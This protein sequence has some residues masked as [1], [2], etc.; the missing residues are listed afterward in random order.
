[1]SAQDEET[2]TTLIKCP[3]VFLPKQQAV[4]D[5][6]EKY[7]YVL[8]S[9][10]FGAGK[11]FLMSHVIIRN[12]IKY[13]KSLAF[14]GSQTVPLL[15]DTVVRTFLEEIDVYQ[16][17]IT[18]AG[19]ELQLCK[20][21]SPSIMKFTFFNGAEVLFRSC[22]EPS[23]F[24]SLNLDCMAIDEP[25]DIDEEVFLMLQGRLRSNKTPHRFAIMAGNP[26]GKT[27][28]VY[29]RFYEK[30]HK[31]Y[32]YVHTTTF[33]NTYLPKDYI[34]SVK[35]SYDEDYA[36]RYLYGEW[37][38]FEG[39]VYKDFNVSTQVATLNKDPTQYSYI[40]A[41]YDDGYRNPACMLVIGI[42]RDGVAHVLEELY[43]SEKT[44][45]ELLAYVGALK[46]KYYISR[47]YADP[48][49]LNFIE[50]ARNKGL[51]VYRADNDI[52]AGIA[53]CKAMFKSELIRIDESCENTIRELESYR[54][55]KDRSN[56]NLSEKPVKKDDHAC[57]AFRYAFTDYNP[58]K[59]RRTL[60]GGHF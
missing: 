11:T 24:K 13:P 20:K 34:E 32:F 58:F 40:V 30:K 33:D 54:Y 27:N 46:H 9:G 4:L 31:D 2:E 55:A 59:K 45:D 17:A 53:K 56:N 50:T 57:D 26:S 10:A 60:K 37:G 19:V 35:T 22:D 23:K 18:K 44:T 49:A 28:W 52:D 6:V 29:Q 39:A 1:M 15:R 42:D 43:E 8:Y 41:G 38:G 47:I 5:A 21:W 48:S 14:F 51:P 25:V 7:K 12:G 3:R 36:R 16:E